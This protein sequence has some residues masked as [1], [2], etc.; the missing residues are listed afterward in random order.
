MRGKLPGA[1]WSGGAPLFYVSPLKAQLL[2]I[3]ALVA[4]A[5]AGMALSRWEKAR[6]GRR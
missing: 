6:R 1:D 3:G 5:L 4:G 2:R